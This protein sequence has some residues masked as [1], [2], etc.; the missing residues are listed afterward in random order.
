MK[1]KTIFLLLSGS[2]ESL[3]DKNETLPMIRRNYYK[4]ARLSNSI[5]STQAE[6]LQQINKNFAQFIIFSFTGLP[7]N[8]PKPRRPVATKLKCLLRDASLPFYLRMS[9]LGEKAQR[10]KKEND[11][12]EKGGTWGRASRLS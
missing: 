5:R 9:G 3:V 2:G 10:G 12:R 6:V 1:K 8:H 7:E 4:Q 11:W